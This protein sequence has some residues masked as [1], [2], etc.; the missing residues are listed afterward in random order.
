M[1]RKNWLNIL[2][3]L[4]ILGAIGF[5]MLCFTSTSKS[6]LPTSINKITN[7]DGK[8]DA[9]ELVYGVRYVIVISNNGDVAITR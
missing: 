6:T 8:A 7:I 3:G 5:T 9:Y 4:L 1:K 2:G